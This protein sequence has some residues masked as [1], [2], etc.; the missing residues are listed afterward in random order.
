VTRRYFRKDA[1]MRSL[2]A[3][4][5]LASALAGC[6]TDGQ[7]QLDR[8]V[9]PVN[10]PTLTRADYVFDASAP[11]GVLAPGESERLDAWFRSMNLGYGDS[12][13]VDG[14]YSGA[15]RGE[16]G[17]LAGMYGLAVQPGAP[18]TAGGIGGENVR[19]IVSRTRAE[20]PNCPNWDRPAHPNWNNPSMP[21]FGCAV[22]SNLAAMVANPEDL[23]NGREG[24]GLGDTLTSSRAID[25][26]RKAEPTGKKGLQDISTKKGN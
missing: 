24:S 26:Y 11:G 12:V 22:N 14:G 3:P 13:H 2:F 15:A 18:V 5:L 16:V 9:S 7:D 21:N 23:I 8:G 20:V 6:V 4:L 1:T 17:Q 19:V 10:V 25:S